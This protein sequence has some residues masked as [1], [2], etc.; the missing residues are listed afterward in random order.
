MDGFNFRASMRDLSWD[1]SSSDRFGPG[2]FFWQNQ[3]A[4]QDDHSSVNCRNYGNF[5]QT[6]ALLP[7]E[8]VLAPNLIHV[9]EA[10]SS[11]SSVASPTP[12]SITPDSLQES[13]TEEPTASKPGWGY[14][15]WT[16]QQQRLLVQLWCDKHT[17]L[18]SRHARKVWEEIAQ[19]LSKKKKV[20]SA[21]CQRKMKHL[22]ERYKA[23]KD[24]NRHQTGGERKTSPF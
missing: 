14:E 12:R 15:K 21:Q 22:K 7:T 18:E 6:S 13:S 5:T 3:G 2:Y 1:D 17:Q 23:A 9:P 10:M 8:P 20:T 24:H 4:I 16:D 19:E 11:S